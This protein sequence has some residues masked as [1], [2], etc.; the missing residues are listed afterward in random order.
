MSTRYRKE[1]DG[2]RA[3]AIL[4]VIFFHLGFPAFGGGFVGVDVFFV[5]SGYLMTSIIVNEHDNGT[6]SLLRFYA[7]RARRILPALL[8]VILCCIP[9]AMYLMPPS[10]YKDFM[11]TV[12]AICLITQNFYLWETSGYF[13]SNSETKP[14]LHTWSLAVEEQFYI[15]FPIIILLLSRCSRKLFYVVLATI[16]IASFIICELGWRLFPSA[17]FYLLPSRIWE[18]LLGAFCVFWQTRRG[19]ESNELLAALGLALI[20]VSIITFDSATPF[21]SYLTL[22]PV[23]G[24]ALIILFAHTDT[25]TGRLLSTKVLVGIGLISYSAYLWH[26]PLFAFAR[27][28]T[29]GRPSDL[30]MGLLAV[31][32]LFF[33]YFSWR[34]VEQ[35]FRKAE[36]LL[37]WGPRSVLLTSALVSVCLMLTSAHLPSPVLKDIAKFKPDSNSGPLYPCFL[38]NTDIMSFKEEECILRNSGGLSRRILLLGDSHAASLGVGLQEWSVKNSIQ[39]STLTAAYCLPLVTTFPSSLSQ[40]ATPRCAAINQKAKELV[41]TQH[42]DLVVI[43]S[44]MLEWGFKNDPKWTYPG[45]FEDFVKEVR[46]LSS[47]VPV[48]VVGQYP[49]WRSSLLEVIWNEMRK[50]NAIS[51]LPQY[52]FNGIDERIFTVDKVER[53]ALTISNV[54]Y[55]S[56]VEKYCRQDGC[57]RYIN[58]ENDVQLVSPDYGHLSVGASVYLAETLIGPQIKK[59]LEAKL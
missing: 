22:L 26:Y 11:K 33:A 2:L 39:L 13:S 54:Y 9:F 31:T 59:I 45:Y 42:F 29:L 19:Q 35:P 15:V 18:L 55:S 53:N 17:N 14:L 12:K 7:R 3:V 49:V 27:I 30:V 10:E 28:H 47:V 6:F 44:F 34:Y 52:S 36:R 38:L 16:G 50:A 40:T 58:Y 5:I 37:A 32:S 20:A 25:L 24:A 43:A 1:L 8:M 46:S 51:A 56:V 48:L 23:A 4:P 21:P 41:A 57:L